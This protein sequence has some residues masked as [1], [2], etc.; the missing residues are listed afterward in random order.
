MRLAATI[1]KNKIDIVNSK[2]LRKDL[3]TIQNE[4]Y[5]FVTQLD[6]IVKNTDKKIINNKKEKLSDFF[7]EFGKKILEP[8]DTIGYPAPEYESYWKFGYDILKKNGEFSFKKYITNITAEITT[9]AEGLYFET[10]KDRQE[11]RNDLLN[12][13]LEELK[14]F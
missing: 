9:Y 8:I 4:V 1:L 3:T 2:E 6:E 12:N 14:N 13:V 5:S 10:D 11:V 7:K